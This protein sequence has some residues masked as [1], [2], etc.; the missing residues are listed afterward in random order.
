MDYILL[1]RV[2][3]IIK[4][5][6][7]HKYKRR[8]CIRSYMVC[9]DKC[10]RTYMSEFYGY[11]YLRIFFTKKSYDCSRNIVPT[12]DDLLLSFELTEFELDIIIEVISKYYNITL[13]R[14]MKLTNKR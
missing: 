6:P 12:L 1:Q 3:N 9:C 11:L 10:N 8:I 4:F 14:K 13:S 7:R 2:L 5:Q